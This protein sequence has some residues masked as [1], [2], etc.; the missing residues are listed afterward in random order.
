MK[1]SLAAAH[2]ALGDLAHAAAHPIPTERPCL[3]VAPAAVDRGPDRAAVLGHTDEER[4]LE[5]APESTQR[6]VQ[7]SHL[8]P[9]P[10]AHNNATEMPLATVLPRASSPP[11]M[12]LPPRTSIYLHHCSVLRLCRGLA[13][14]KGAASRAELQ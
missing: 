8:E 11:C 10:L 14:F 12:S 4:R 6:A 7:L 3:D 13:F 9:L 5:P 1:E 2:H